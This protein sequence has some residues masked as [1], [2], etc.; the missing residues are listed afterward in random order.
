MFA[1]V[2]V[3]GRIG[4]RDEIER[5]LHLLRLR[6]KNHCVIVPE[7][8]PF[9]GMLQKA[10]DYITWGE[11]DKDT[12]IMLLKKRGRL[13]GDRRLTEE[14]VKEKTGK[15]L[16]EFAKDVLEGKAKLTDLPGIKP[17]FRLKPPSKGF[18]RGGIK[19]PFSVGGALGYRGKHIND[20]LKR[21][22]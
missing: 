18:E 4:V 6:K 3:R 10:K 12:L 11:I 19:K 8:Q 9:L 14:Y 1:V 13:A 16:E 22:I 20:L 17:F 2:R 15:S 21:M 7:T 5:T